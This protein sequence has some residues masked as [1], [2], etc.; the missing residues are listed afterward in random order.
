MR[1]F[2]CIALGCLVSLSL[3]AAEVATGRSAPTTVVALSQT[4]CEAGFVYVQFKDSDEWFATPRTCDVP[5]RSQTGRVSTTVP[6]AQDATVDGSKGCSRGYIGVTS[7]GKSTR[8]VR[9]V[10]EPPTTAPPAGLFVACPYPQRFSTCHG[11]GHWGC[12]SQNGE[13][14]CWTN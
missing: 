11:A 5:L 1:N 6:Q 7:D 12:G 3:G 13:R 10:L 14:G 8:C 4:K 9:M 2:A